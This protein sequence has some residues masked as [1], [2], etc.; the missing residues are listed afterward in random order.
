MHPVRFVKA[1]P[2]GTVVSMAAG[3]VVGPWVLS[4]INNATGV[5]LTL[6]TYGNGGG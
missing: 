3:M 5:G 4:M 6:P 1:H 2:L